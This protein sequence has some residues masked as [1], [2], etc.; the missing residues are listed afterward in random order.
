MGVL[1]QSRRANK[2]EGKWSSNSLGY[3]NGRTPF[4]IGC[5]IIIR[6]IFKRRPIRPYKLSKSLIEEQASAAAAI[7]MDS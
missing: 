7:L 3:L 5:R 4:H 2:T 1:A 6:I